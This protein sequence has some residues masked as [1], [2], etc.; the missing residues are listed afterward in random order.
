MQQL[1]NNIVAPLFMPNGFYVKGV[2]TLYNVDTA[3]SKLDLN[4]L[5]VVVQKAGT[6]TI[7]GCTAN[8]LV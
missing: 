6:G 5:Y 3:G 8:K 7:I 1:N 4:D 2:S